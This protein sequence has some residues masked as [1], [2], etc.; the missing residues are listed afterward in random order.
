MRPMPELA[1]EEAP[2]EGLI[3]YA[4]NAKIHTNEQ[5]DQIAASIEEFGFNDPVAVW[6]SPEG[7][8]IVEGHLRGSRGDTAGRGQVRQAAGRKPVLPRH[9]RLHEV[10]FRFNRKPRRADPE[11]VAYLDSR[12][13]A[14]EVPLAIN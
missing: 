14:D 8:E 2:T 1:V 9:A 5:I 12:L 10:M 7:T 13:G 3:P 6:D 11:G 4:N